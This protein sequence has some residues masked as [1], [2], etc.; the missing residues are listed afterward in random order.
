ME[1]WNYFKK[2]QEIKPKCFVCGCGLDVS[3]NIENNTYCSE[4][5]KQRSNNIRKCFVCGDNFDRSKYNIKHMYC[6]QK[7]KENGRYKKN[8]KKVLKENKKW[9]NRNKNY[10]SDRYKTDINFKLRRLFRCRI[11]YAIKKGSNAKK[12]YGTEKLIGCTFQEAREHIEKQ[13]KVGM[14]WENHGRY[15][16]HIDHIIPCASF[17]L[18]DIEQQKKCFNYTN[19]QPLWAEENIAKGARLL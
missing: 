18:T 11:K 10:V 9:R 3:K 8:P 2:L 5:C 16:W 4:Y 15:G 7:C 12:A 19:L 17:D 1:C 13:F 14:T 6:S